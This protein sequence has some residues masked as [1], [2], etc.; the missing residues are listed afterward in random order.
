MILDKE[1]HLEGHDELDPAIWK[2]LKTT[3]NIG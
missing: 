1:D 2:H 3:S